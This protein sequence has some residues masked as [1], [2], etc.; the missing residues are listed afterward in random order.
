MPRKFNLESLT[1]KDPFIIHL[2]YSLLRIFKIIIIIIIIII[3]R[4]ESNSEL[5]RGKSTNS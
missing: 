2:F 1:A 3:N 4:S 5:L